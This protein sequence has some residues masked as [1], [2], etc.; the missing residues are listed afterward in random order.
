MGQRRTFVLEFHDKGQTAKLVK[1]FSESIPL[2]I[3]MA[4]PYDEVVIK[5][6]SPGGAVADYGLASSQMLRLKRAGIATTVCVD[7]MA[8]SGGYMMACVADKLIAAPF[9]FLGSIGVWLGCPTYTVCFKR[10]RLTTCYSL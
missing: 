6:T 9:S 3:A 7:T 2:M 1:Q 8:A 10:T 4:S 5:L